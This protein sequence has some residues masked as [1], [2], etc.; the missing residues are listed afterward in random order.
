MNARVVSVN[1][2]RERGTP[3][4]PVEKGEFLAEYGMRGDGHSGPWHRQ[5]SLFDISAL[6]ELEPEDRSACEK[7]YSEN[8]T[9]DGIELWKLPV[10]S[11][12][13][14]GGTVLELQQIGKDFV[15]DPGE[16]TSSEVIM[17]EKGIFCTVLESGWVRPGD[18]L[19][20]VDEKHGADR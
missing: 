18:T 11:K 2:S 6:A 9:T 20:V 14:V 4:Y 3:K 13:A 16:H 5:V 15:K 8:I 10:G 1:L 19:T 17:H 12:I 7:S